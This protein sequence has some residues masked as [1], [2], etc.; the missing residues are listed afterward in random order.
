MLQFLK[1][2]E[3]TMQTDEL[4]T[5]AEILAGALSGSGSMVIR[6]VARP[7][8]A[9]LP[10]WMLSEVDAMAAMSRKSRNAMLIQLIDVALEATRKE[11]DDEHGQWLNEQTTQRLMVLQADKVGQTEEEA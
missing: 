4:P 6:G 8:L 3:M 2:C 5:K 9:R 11:L 1:E 10:I 7:V